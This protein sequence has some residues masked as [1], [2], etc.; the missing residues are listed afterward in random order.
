LRLATGGAE[1][2]A[3][4]GDSVSFLTG[5]AVN[6][7]VE[8]G[9]ATVALIGGGFLEVD[10]V[11]AACGSRTAFS[12]RAGAAKSLVIAG[13]VEGYMGRVD[14]G[15]TFHYD[16]PLV[17]IPAQVVAPRTSL[18]LTTPMVVPVGEGAFIDF[19]LQSY[20]TPLSVQIDTASGGTMS[21]CSS[22]LPSQVVFGNAAML[23]A[24]LNANGQSQVQFDWTTFAVVPSGNAVAEINQPLLRAGGTALTNTDRAACYR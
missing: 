16:R 15:Q 12:V 19:N 21:K 13:S 18:T 1:I 23:Y 2:R 14:P 6:G 11:P 24:P 9:R 8:C 10:A 5:D 22:Q 17:L 4:A 3:L 7:F 20:I